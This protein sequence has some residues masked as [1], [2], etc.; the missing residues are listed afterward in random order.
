MTMRA[1]TLIG[2]PLTAG[3]GY[4]MLLHAQAVTAPQVP[5]AIRVPPGE[6]LVLGA[7]A[8]GAQIYVCAGGTDGKP[9]WTLKAPDAELRDA[10]GTL[11]IHHSAGPSWKHQDGS[12]VTG[13]AVERAPS[14]EA[15]SIPWLLLVAMSH[16]GNGVLA[17]VTHI[18]RVNTHGG[19]P[20]P[21]AQCV[22][23]QPN[24]EVRIPYTADYYFYAAAGAAP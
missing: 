7:H 14:P 9:Q 16:A 5:E 12:E 3:L 18:Q 19:Q 21:A 24:A 15:D 13:K 2:L 17:H 23:A 4:A 8:S 1:S 11:V 22:S 6:K 10:K 20:P